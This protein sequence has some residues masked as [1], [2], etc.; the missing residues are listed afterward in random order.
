MKITKRQL[1]R[2]I[3]EETSRLLKESTQHPYDLA[4][5]QAEDRSSSSDV[6]DEIYI[7]VSATLGDN[8]PLA[9]RISNLID[10]QDAD[11]FDL[12]EEIEWAAADGT[13]PANIKD[14][15]LAMGSFE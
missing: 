8:H 2:I 11:Y 6:Q 1:R 4:A 9:Q 15:L 10:G 13:A 12:L 7:D 5:E 3:K 14:R